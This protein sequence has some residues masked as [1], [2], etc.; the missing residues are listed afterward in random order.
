MTCIARDSRKLKQ[1]LCAQGR[2]GIPLFSAK[3]GEFDDLT[4]IWIGKEMPRSRHGGVPRLGDR[5]SVMAR[6]TTF[7]GSSAWARPQLSGS[8]RK[9]GPKPS[10][11][12]QR[13]LEPCK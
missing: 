9:P 1:F 7:S 2:K 4:K 12:C 5:F 13:R 3:R 8:L 6:V 10:F 11:R